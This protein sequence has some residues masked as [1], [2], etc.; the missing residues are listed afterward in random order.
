[1]NKNHQSPRGQKHI[2][3]IKIIVRINNGITINGYT[4]HCG[5]IETI[6]R[7]W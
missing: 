5:L 4:V 7:G 1:M 2:R 3:I 6:N